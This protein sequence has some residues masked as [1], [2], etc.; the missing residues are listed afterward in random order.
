MAA[1]KK[2]N[3]MLEARARHYGDLMNKI[4]HYEEKNQML[5]L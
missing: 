5:E 2:A 1:E 4:K 3:Q